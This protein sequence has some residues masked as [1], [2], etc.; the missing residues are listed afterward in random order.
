MLAAL[1]GAVARIRDLVTI[2]SE[3]DVRF[4]AKGPEGALPIAPWF[5]DAEGSARGA[6]LSPTGRSGE[7]GDVEGKRIVVADDDAAITWFLAGVLRAAGAEVFEAHDGERALEVAYR[8]A[9]DLVISDVLMPI[10][11]GFALCRALRRDLAL[12]DVPVIL[13][14]WKEDLLQRVR[15]L[16]AD[17][18]GYLKKEASAGAIV[19]RVREVIRGRQR[20]GERIARGGEVRGRLDG[21]TTKTL[22]AHTCLHRPVSTLAVRDACFLYEVAIRNGAP[23]RA[24][25]T[26]PDGTFQRGPA[27][28]AGLLGVGAGRFVVSPVEGEP[29]SARVE[30]EGTLA[31]QLLGPIATRA[32]RSAS[33]RA[34]RSSPSSASTSTP[35]A[36]AR[37][38]T[39]RPN[40]LDRSFA[41]SPPE[42]RR[43]RSSPRAKPLRASSKTCSATPPRAARSPPCSAPAARICSRPPSSARRRRCEAFAARSPSCCRRATSAPSWPL[44]R[45]APSR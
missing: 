13:L 9:P 3:G 24:T 39:R 29:K 4:A 5:D 43:A 2:H 35:I 44:A 10:V 33:C 6:R 12:R 41:P 34:P 32:P 26:A 37:T 7:L 20:V 22:L 36:W 21:L 8:C 28:L 25:R 30:L 17:A 16:G 23:A 38:P 11:D 19:Q 14:S 15:E 31:E 45:P 27:V 40:P 18:D 42:H 1:W